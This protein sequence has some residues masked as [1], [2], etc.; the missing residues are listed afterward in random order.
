M[1]RYVDNIKQSLTSVDM[2][3]KKTYIHPEE[4]GNEK[5]NQA[6]KNSY[7]DIVILDNKTKDL[8]TAVNELLE[9]TVNRLD[10]VMD[11][12]TSEKER[13]QD[14]VMLCNK[15]TDFE[16]A[17]ILT[18][19]DFEG[20]YDY[21]KGVF[22][23]RASQ[24]HNMTGTI[25]AIEGNGYIGNK[26]VWNE[27]DYQEKT[28]STKNEFALL[29]NDVSTYWEYSRVTAASTEEY[30]IADFHN[31]DA[32]ANCTI[33]FKLNNAVNEL[34]LK[35]NLNTVK[36][37]GVRYSSDGVKYND[38]DILPFTLNKKD[39]SYKN[40]GYI[41]GSNIISFPSS[42]YIRVTFQS[43]G[44]LNET[45]AFERT[46]TKENSDT[47]TTYTTIV[48][49]AKRHV[50]R[51]NDV[52]FKQKK[53]ASSCIIKSKELINSD[54]NIFAISVFANTYIPEGVSPK[55]ISFVLTV[56]GND[57]EV[58]PV[59]SNENGTKV[60]RFSQGK[61]PNEYTQYIGEKIQSAFLT[62]KMTPQNNLT[63]Y[64]N[65]LK[66]LLGDEI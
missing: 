10:V 15:Q 65:N 3:Y 53:Y 8:A 23:C 43:T 41:Y 13:L 35:S 18:D 19:D 64:I 63:P 27:K 39:D 11:I 48:P 50:V 57:Y 47:I 40:Q 61:I 32:E 25:D 58:I 12:I 5:I 30:L 24:S 34:L 49:T 55:S 56:N 17:I 14:I 31:D 51:L 26:Y 28:L 38:L 52:L 54:L 9:K 66:I 36:V 21:D 29:D 45:L 37:I 33:T 2:K 7:E 62:I 20:E 4:Y 16:N 59:N 44:Y 42:K 22:S 60:I 6:I 46:V 1:N